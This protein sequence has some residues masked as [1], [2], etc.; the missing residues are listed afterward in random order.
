MLY[1]ST[2]HLP[3]CWIRVR[4]AQGG[5][6]AFQQGRPRAGSQFEGDACLIR[7]ILSFIQKRRITCDSLQFLAPLEAERT[8]LSKHFL[9]RVAQFRAYLL[10]NQKRILKRHKQIE[11]NVSPPHFIQEANQER[12]I[13]AQQKALLRG[14]ASE[15]NL[16][17]RESQ[18]GQAIPR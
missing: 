1:K 6:N 15:G 12:V 13:R 5:R 2:L 11:M 8:P 9:P 7:V 3:L 4:I 18:S 17:S 10:S 16:P 14:N